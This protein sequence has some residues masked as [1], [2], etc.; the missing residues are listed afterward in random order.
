M[1]SIAPIVLVD[2]TKDPD[3]N[4]TFAPIS[5]QNGRALF[6]DK[7]DQRVANWPKLSAGASAPNNSTGSGKAK[8]TLTVPVPVESI[9]GCCSDLNAPTVI[10][11]EANTTLPVTAGSGIALTAL[12]LF[13]SYVNSSD[14]E[15]LFMGETYY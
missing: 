13:R 1:P 7:A 10:A 15:K 8:V 3:V 2:T 9:E 11:L 14:F 12:S 5:N 6:T 4:H